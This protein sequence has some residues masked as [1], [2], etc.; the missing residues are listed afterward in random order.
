MMLYECDLN[1]Y[2]EIVLGFSDLLRME[3]YN[4]RLGDNLEADASIYVD[5]KRKYKFIVEAGI[6]NIHK[7]SVF[8]FVIYRFVLLRFL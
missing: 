7:A 6:S 5:S 4:T 1:S 8:N 2:A 3:N